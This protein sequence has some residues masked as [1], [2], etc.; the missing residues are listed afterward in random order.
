MWIFLIMLLILEKF[1]FLKIFWGIFFCGVIPAACINISH[2][3]LGTIPFLN[4]ILKFYNF[5][6]KMIYFDLREQY[7]FLI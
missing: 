2:S 5:Y 1:I 3:I 4:Q 7:L 6:K